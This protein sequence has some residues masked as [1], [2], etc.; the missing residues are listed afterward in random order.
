VTQAASQFQNGLGS[1][2]RY[3][4]L[5]DVVRNRMTDSDA[6]EEQVQR[7]DDRRALERQVAH[8]RAHRL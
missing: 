5:M 6:R 4:A 1:R 7:G 8:P 2:T 3:D